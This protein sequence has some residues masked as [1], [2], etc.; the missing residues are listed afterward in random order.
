MLIT[1]SMAAADELFQTIDRPSAIDPLAGTGERPEECKGDVQL[2]DVEFTYPSRPDAKILD[3]L[4]INVPAGK[5]TALVGASGS[6]KSTIIGLLERW[7]LPTD[8]K[9]T[10]DGKDISTLNVQW[11][12]TQMRLVQQEPVLFSGTIFQNVVNG[13]IGT[14][15]ADASDEKKMEL[16]EEAC[17]AA[18]AHD[19]ISELT[20]GYHTQIGER[21]ALLSGGQKQRI[22]IARSIISNPKILLLDEATSAL[23]PKAE[24]IVQEALDNVSTGRT[25]IVIAHKL[26]TIKN[27]HNIIVMSKGKV[28]EQGTHSELIAAGGAYKRLVDAQDLGRNA[29]AQNGS[30]PD[31]DSKSEEEIVST[32]ELARAVTTKSAVSAMSVV[33]EEE[34]QS[35]GYG[36][37][38]VLCIILTENKPMRIFFFIIFVCTVLGGMDFAGGSLP[39]TVC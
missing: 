30:D 37:F 26:S 35:A 14:P 32:T 5:T 7:Y 9:I 11:L 29:A 15:Y 20:D 24:R 13:L 1:K 17:K 8:G 28:V 36:L 19:F 23:D 22:A 21:A 31:E 4:S 16:V 3:R 12:R 6:G 38:K 39:H 25:T 27:A 18:Y 2:F 34:K 33:A 10:L